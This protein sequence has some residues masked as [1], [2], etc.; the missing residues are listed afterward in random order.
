MSS[1]SSSVSPSADEPVT[2][3]MRACSVASSMVTSKVPR[4]GVDDEV[5][6]GLPESLSMR[7]LSMALLMIVFLASCSGGSDS[8][9]W[10]SATTT[11]ESDS[12]RPICI[13]VGCCA[14]P[15]TG[16]RTMPGATPINRR[17]ALPSRAAPGSADSGPGMMRCNHALR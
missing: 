17:P 11:W 7:S 16:W 13:R 3:S 14:N 1:R 10:K 6:T 8:S 15:S 12:R 5:D 9:V 2:A 4:R